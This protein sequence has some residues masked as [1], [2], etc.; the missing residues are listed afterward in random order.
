MFA[1]E[2]YKFKSSLYAAGELPAFESNE[3]RKHILECSSCMVDLEVSRWL[4]NQL[5]F[6]DEVD[7]PDFLVSRIMASIEREDLTPEKNPARSL[8]KIM[9]IISGLISFPIISWFL[10]SIIAFLSYDFRLP[11]S[12]RESFIAQI[13]ITF[14]K[15]L[16]SIFN[17]SLLA[18]SFM[19]SERLPHLFTLL[20]IVFWI[21][22]TSSLF[23]SSIILFATARVKVIPRSTR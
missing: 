7:P 15:S 17:D 3:I 12:G 2:D 16:A 4:F 10:K 13:F 14:A 20:I 1:C 11:L 5:D 8:F 18:S 22:L 23:F 6:M 9:A 21:A 19:V